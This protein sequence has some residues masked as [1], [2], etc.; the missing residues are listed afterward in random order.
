MNFPPHATRAQV[1]ALNTLEIEAC[2]FFLLVRD[3]HIKR[4]VRG[5]KNRSVD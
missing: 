5:D 3:A 4:N 1:L 2:F